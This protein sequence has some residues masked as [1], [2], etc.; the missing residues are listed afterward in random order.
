VSIL[1]N[2]VAFA[3]V[4]G[5][6]VFVH[7]LGHFLAAKRI[8][9]KVLRF[10][11]GF[12]PT[13]VKF[14]RGDTEYSIGAIPFGGFVKM[15]GENPEDPH[16]GSPEEFLS[17][18]KWERFQVLVMGPVMNIGLALGVL[19]LV[20]YYGATIDAYL[21]QPVDVA[22]VRS[23]SPA[24][25]A[26][27]HP[28]DRIVSVAGRDVATWEDF[29][30][31]VGTK[32]DRDIEIGYRRAGQPATIRLTPK[33]AEGSYQTG[34]I[35]VLPIVRPQL[36]SVTSSGAGA[37]AGLMADDVVLAVDGQPV[38]S[39]EEFVK[40]VNAKPEQAIPIVVRRAGAEVTVTATPRREGD[41]GRLG[42]EVQG[43]SARVQVGLAEAARLSVQKNIQ[44]SGLIYQTVWG[45]FTRETSPKQLMGPVAIAKLSG[46]SAQLGWVHLLNLLAQISLNLGILN[47][48]PIPVLDGG[49]IF[50][51]A[52]EGVARRDFSLRVKEKLLLGGFALL[53]VLMATV[54]YNDLANTGIFQRLIPWR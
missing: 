36:K 9:I 3:F 31:A 45:L 47:L 50:I 12:D 51:L 27:I 8:G 37:A 40:A 38:A 25:V 41:V 49:H 6:L 20:L 43:E 15:A 42:V 23:G 34:E 54:M 21:R 28:G 18:S 16:S 32:P 35:G 11:I 52:M 4:I 26:G 29:I 33:A 2:V 7:E 44:Y 13:I 1:I 19:T 53:M 17:R 30:V 39:V 24:E 48:L 5:V 10:Q 22:A 46:E 14:R